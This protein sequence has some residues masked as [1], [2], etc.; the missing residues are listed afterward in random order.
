MNFL[1]THFSQGGILVSTTSQDFPLDTYRKPYVDPIGYPKTLLEN[2]GYESKYIENGK[3][4]YHSI[5]MPELPAGT[6]YMRPFMI[7]YFGGMGSYGRLFNDEQ[8]IVI[9]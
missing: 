9:E 1:T 3:S 2:F 7:D 8:K 6:Y 5:C 4:V